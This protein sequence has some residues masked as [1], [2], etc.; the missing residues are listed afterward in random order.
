MIHRLQAERVAS[1]RRESNQGQKNNYSL[2][3]QNEGIH[4]YCREHNY[5]M[6]TEHDYIDI[7]TGIVYREREA[8]NALRAAARRHEFDVVIVYDLDRFSRNPIHQMIVLEDLIN[9]GVRVEC[10]LRTIHD[11]P[12]GQLT[13]FAQGYAA[14]LEHE[15]ILERT[16]RGRRARAEDGK[17][18]ATG[19][20]RYGYQWANKEKTR[21]ELNA[22]VVY[23]DKNGNQWKEGDVAVYVFDL[24]DRGYSLNRIVN[25]LNE[26]QIPTP[27]GNSRWAAT[28]IR[29][30]LGDPIYTGRPLAFKWVVERDAAYKRI[31][32]HRAR[33]KQISLPAGTAPALVC[34]ERF[35]RVQRQIQLNKERFARTTSNQEDAL[36]QGGLVVCGYCGANMSVSRHKDYAVYTCTIGRK[37]YGTQECKFLSISARKLDDALWQQ[38]IEI[39]QNAPLIEQ[40]VSKRRQLDITSQDLTPINNLLIKLR[41]QIQNYNL[42]I[43]STENVDVLDA[44]IGELNKLA[45]I[46][47]ELNKMRDALLVEHDEWKQSE[48]AL[49]KFEEW[50]TNFREESVVPAFKEKRN[51]CEILG[52]KAYVWKATYSPHYV[53]KANL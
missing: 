20:P 29:R 37:G 9:H 14:Q 34:I 31:V 5:K 13:L 11:S 12:E 30:I 10:V 35:E 36:L 3:T 39:I 22:K 51:I 23:I 32:K 18:L 4:R 42:A 38:A 41:R 7:K 6:N 47:N 40:V 33:E 2:K 24:A 43:S 8:L 15:R 25:S 1:Y 28:T 50:C 49:D 16:A 26:A 45:K 53:I 17:P 44:L 48:N 27:K 19:N 52:L 46:A 21:Y